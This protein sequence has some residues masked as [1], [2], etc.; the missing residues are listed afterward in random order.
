MRL[1]DQLKPLHNIEGDEFLQK[2][3]IM[4]MKHVA[5]VANTGQRCVVAFLQIPNKEDHALVIP[6]DNL[7]P[8]F[9]QAVNDVLKTPEGQQEYDFG[10]A[11]GWH[12]MPDTHE[13]I[14]EALHKTGKLVPVPVTNVTMLPMPNM[15]QKLSTMLEQLGR[16]PQQQMPTDFETQKFNPHTYNQQSESSEN[17]RAIAR[18]LLVEAEMLEAE[19]KKKRDQAYAADTSLKPNGYASLPPQTAMPSADYFYLPGQTPSAAVMQSVI[20]TR[21]TQSFEPVESSVASGLDGRLSAL[22]EMFGKLAERLMP[23]PAEIVPLD[24]LSPASE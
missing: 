1:Q 21:P 18:G 17:K 20:D 15:P 6:T 19:A 22:E 16:L 3:N 5:R 8:R 9:E 10:N 12:L 13:T 4:M 7:P 14:L 11:L 24:D 2:E 23:M